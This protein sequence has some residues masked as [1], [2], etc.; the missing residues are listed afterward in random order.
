[1]NVAILLRSRLA[2][3]FARYFIASIL[4]LVMDISLLLLLA[5]FVHYTIAASISFIAGSV[6][7]YWLSVLFV[8]QRRKLASRKWAESAIFVAAGVFGLVVNV[9]VIALCVELFLAPLI[10]AKLIAAGFSFM[11]GYVVRKLALF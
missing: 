1:M 8:F 9:G 2:G 10:V 7:H 6:V 3:E 5:K 11:S 4:A